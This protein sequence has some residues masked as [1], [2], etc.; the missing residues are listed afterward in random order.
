TFQI[1]NDIANGLNHLHDNGI[2]YRDL[3]GIGIKTNKEK[4]FEYYLE[5]AT[6]N[7]FSSQYNVAECYKNGFGIEKNLDEAE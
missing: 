7:F 4:A 1:A 5:A 3:F 2:I 6:Q